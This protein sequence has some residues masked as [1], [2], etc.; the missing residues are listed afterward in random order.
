MRS[1]LLCFLAALVAL[2]SSSACGSCGPDPA[3]RGSASAAWSITVAGQAVTCAHV[4]AASVSLVVHSRASGDDT[5]SSFAC[6]DAEGSTPPVPAGVYDATLALHA[7]DGATLATAPMQAAVTIAAEQVT[8][9]RPAV[10]PV[11]E[12]G[13]LVLSFVAL[14]ASA[15]CTPAD[16]GGAGLTGFTI[17]FEHAADGCAPVTFTRARGTATLGTYTI[18]VPISGAFIALF[19]V[20][21]LVNGWRR[22]FAG[23][24]DADIVVPVVT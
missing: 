15:N 23:P 19:A 24:E 1:T 22:G 6:T 20:E 4:G 17:D 21:Q 14:T 18:I 11:S 2:T 12:R 8:A 7:A 13:K 5:V 9:L 10:F 3:A 16:Q